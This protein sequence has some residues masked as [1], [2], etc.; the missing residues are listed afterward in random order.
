[1]KF[2]VKAVKFRLVER[3]GECINNPKR[4]LVGSDSPTQRFQKPRPHRFCRQAIVEIRS[5]CVGL[6]VGAPEQVL[7]A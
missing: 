1:M 4:L 3:S 2:G 7:S 5:S 6:C